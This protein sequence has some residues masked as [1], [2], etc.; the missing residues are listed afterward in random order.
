[1][2]VDIRYL[3]VHRWSVSALPNLS[4]QRVPGIE[5]HESRTKLR[6][7]WYLYCVAV[8]QHSPRNLQGCW[9]FCRSADRRTS[10]WHTA[11]ALG[12][13]TCVPCGAPECR[14]KSRRC[15][16]L[17]AHSAAS[18]HSSWTSA[19]TTETTAQPQN[20]IQYN[21]IK[22]EVKNA[23]G[24]AVTSQEKRRKTDESWV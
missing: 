23:N 12:R 24:T 6:E 1:M 14:G 9:T 7:N 11:P 20:Q 8:N 19:Y 16:Q 10:Y 3:I 21:T 15:R 5:I 13:R 4:A 22:F 2:A 17:A 18:Q